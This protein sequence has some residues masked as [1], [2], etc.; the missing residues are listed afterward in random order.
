MVRLKIVKSLTA[1]IAASAILLTVPAAAAP[2]FTVFA[3]EE[4]Q[5]T[6]A[7]K[8]AETT[9]PKET[10]KPTTKATSK[11]AET[12]KQTSAS[13][14]AETSKQTEATKPAETTK[15][16][17]AKTAE[18]TKATESNKPAETTKHTES[19]KPAETAKETGTAPTSES[20]KPAETTAPTESKPVETKPTEESAKPAEPTE[21][22]AETAET[23][24]PSETE[25]GQEE[26]TSSDPTEST[27]PTES[28]ET[29]ETSETSEPS[30]TTKVQIVSRIG[31]KGK[32][33]GITIDGQFA[34]WDSVV[35]YNFLESDNS[36]VNYAAMV[37]DG[38]W[39]YIYMDE[40]QQ[41]SATWSGPHT[42]G[43]FVIKT[44]TG[45][46]LV[47]NLTDNG[48][49]GNKVKVSNKFTGKTLTSENGG[50]KVAFNDQYAEWGAPTLT[51]IAIPTSVLPDYKKTISFGF[52]QGDLI[53]KNV[54]NLHPVQSEDPHEH[55]DNDGSKIKI[56]GKYTDWKNYP[57]TLIEYDTDG[58]H[59][60]FADAEGGIYQKSSKT[61]YVHAYTN[62]FQEGPPDY[63]GG[64]QFL[65][66][67]LK[68][69]GKYTKMVACLVDS[70][71][72]INW[73]SSENDKHYKEGTYKF[74]LFEQSGSHATK[75]M[76]N[77]AP[78]DTFY[79]YQ[80]LT[81][82][83]YVDETEFSIDTEA[84]AKHL[85]L[86]LTQAAELKVYFHRVGKEPLVASGISTGPVFTV[87]LTSVAAGSY[88]VFT[89]RKRRQA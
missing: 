77:I 19:S 82:R 39:I 71:G 27:E 70:N 23:T 59:H 37:W 58:A 26:T 1:F 16:T 36:K 33:N 32:Y 87:A 86:T 38:D 52:Y 67:T 20:N 46:D 54:A 3:E 48:K 51:E 43:S 2:S 34:D 57:H 14:P 88:Y 9:K 13:K 42:N 74:A 45:K 81:V 85:G 68:F 60:N 80:Y 7:H 18:T 15:H 12:T 65:E 10:T 25:P 31:A 17:E 62:D 47:I 55:D 21:S 83:P 50:V 72:N 76:N 64:N 4:V 22:S 56:D 79:G 24:Q 63:Y 89:R 44:D 28:S 61:V 53:I 8:T 29:S 73:N 5:E 66:I 30:E 75:N 84:L 49:N 41:N 78:G 11:P 69:G 35:K 6:T 40:V